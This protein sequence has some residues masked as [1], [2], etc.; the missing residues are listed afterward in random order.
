MLLTEYDLRTSFFSPREEGT[1]ATSDKQRA[2]DFKECPSA[3]V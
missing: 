3:A 2:T 1:Q